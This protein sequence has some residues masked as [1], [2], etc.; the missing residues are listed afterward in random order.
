MLS[1]A[2]KLE[3]HDIYEI[4]KI[5]FLPTVPH[6]SFAGKIHTAPQQSEDDCLIEIHLFEYNNLETFNISSFKML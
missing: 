1:T 5:H 2:F 6:I 3:F 4:N